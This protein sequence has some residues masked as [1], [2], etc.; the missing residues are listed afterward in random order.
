MTKLFQAG[1]AG[2]QWLQETLTPWHNSPQL[3]YI[4]ASS[5]LSHGKSSCPAHSVVVH[6]SHIRTLVYRLIDTMQ[7]AQLRLAVFCWFSCGSTRCCVRITKVGP[8]EYA[9]T[10]PV[11]AWQTH[12]EYEPQWKLSSDMS[13]RTRI[14]AKQGVHAKQRHLSCLPEQFVQNVIKIGSA[15]FLLWEHT[16]IWPLTLTFGKV[17]MLT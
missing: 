10:E 17:T 14:C 4:A 16:E 11:K 9:P 3:T 7:S 15:M 2:C 6:A 1:Q 13:F 12:S 5:S 8:G